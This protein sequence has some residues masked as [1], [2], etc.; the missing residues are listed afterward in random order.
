MGPGVPSVIANWGEVDIIEED[1]SVEISPVP[2]GPTSWYGAAG[3]LDLLAALVKGIAKQ[4]DVASLCQTETTL[5][6]SRCLGCLCN[7]DRNRQFPA[8]SYTS[9]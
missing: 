9:L 6:F 7:F 2:T 4:N 5:G 1:E 3:A 8:D